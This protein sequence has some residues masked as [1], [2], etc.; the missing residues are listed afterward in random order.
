MVKGKDSKAAE[1]GQRL[2]QKGGEE[3]LWGDKKLR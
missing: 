2:R 3:V 1:R